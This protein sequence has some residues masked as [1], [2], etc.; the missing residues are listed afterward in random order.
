[1]ATLV[2]VVKCDVLH[3][4]PPQDRLRELVTAMGRGGGAATGPL[5]RASALVRLYTALRGVAGM[6]F[7]EDEVQLLSSLITATPAPAAPPT[8]A[9]AKFVSL[10]LCLL[11]SCNSLISTPAL[12]K[13][14]VEWLRRLIAEAEAEE[15]GEGGQHAGSFGEMLL[16]VAIHFHSNQ[17]WGCEGTQTLSFIN[18]NTLIFA[19]EPPFSSFHSKT[20]TRTV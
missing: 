3:A 17:G 8:P 4:S 18:D 6:K 13:R 1:M 10:G 5:V 15:E 14:A 9:G 12:E 16:L 20:E 2:F 7:T 19:F 11:L